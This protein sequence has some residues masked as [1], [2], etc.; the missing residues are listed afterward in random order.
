MVCASKNGLNKNVSFLTKCACTLSNFG[1]GNKKKNHSL[2]PSTSQLI[3]LQ[4][5]IPKVSLILFRHV[6]EVHTLRNH[7]NDDS[8]SAELHIL[9]KAQ[10]YVDIKTFAELVNGTLNLRILGV[11]LKP[12]Y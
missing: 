8:G 1:T 11:S 4:Y 5:C 9:V 7:S 12:R 2:L 3:Q 6:L 10:T